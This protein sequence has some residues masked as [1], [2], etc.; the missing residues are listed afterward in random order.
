[1]K[2]KLKTL[3]ILVLAVAS[4]VLLLY[5]S[6]AVQNAENHLRTAQTKLAKEKNAL[7]VLDA[8]W[9]FLSAPERLET[10]VNKYFGEP[11][12]KAEIISQDT[13]VPHQSP[14]F[15]DASYSEGIVP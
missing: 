11:A 1:M 14:S 2:F 9:A 12:A 6:Q 7:R 3:M 10:L 13:L 15:Y 5:T 4:G 8:E